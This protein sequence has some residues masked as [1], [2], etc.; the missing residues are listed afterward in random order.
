MTINR[1]APNVDVGAL[2]LLAPG[3]A[4]NRIVKL[5]KRLVS[6]N[7]Y[8]FKHH[9]WFTYRKTPRVDSRFMSSL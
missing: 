7:S 3:K 6:A 8:F 5:L 9:H 2:Q 1:F 4:Q